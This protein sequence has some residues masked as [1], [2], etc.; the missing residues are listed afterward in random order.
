MS[1]FSRADRF[2]VPIHRIGRPEHQNLY[3]DQNWGGDTYYA[4]YAGICKNNSIFRILELGV[5]LG[6]SACAMLLGIEARDDH[7]YW[8]VYV[9]LDG[10][11]EEAG[12]N[13]TARRNIKALCPDAD[14]H[15]YRVNFLYDDIP[16]E[17]RALA[18]YDL[19]HVD[20]I[21]NND[22]TY[23]TL[24]LAWP[25]LAPGGLLILDDAATKPVRAGLWRFLDGL[26][27]KDETLTFQWYTNE[28]GWAIL[29]KEG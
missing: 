12:S 11:V 2:A 10:E 1:L 13:E 15:L 26:M 17:V 22:G 28:R 24:Q 18:P 14:L 19:I 5:F 7:P 23:L 29:R 27:E 25:L 8:P 16:A 20:A 6:Y 4:D 21:H 3:G 9:G